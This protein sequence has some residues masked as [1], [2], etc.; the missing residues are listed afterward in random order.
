M[1]ELAL[2]PAH[3]GAIRLGYHGSV[4]VTSRIVRLA[5][6]D[7]SAVS[8]SQYDIGDPFRELRAGELDLIIVKFGLDEP[9]LVISRIL[10]HDA[11][12]VV[13]AADHPLARHDS[14]SL[15]DIAD[16]DVFDRP[17]DFPAYV[18]D[19]VVPTRT[20]SGRRIHRGHRVSSI[21]QM[22]KLVASG[23]G[24]HISLISLAEVAPPGIR[25]VPIHDMRPAPV[26]VAWL[27]GGNVP[28]HVLDFVAAAEKGAS[29]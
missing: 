15:E 17:G 25:V 11:R 10:T 21:P 29:R 19:E 5:R 18:W 1:P 4:E 27:R 26:T 2:S 6:H 22:M 16:Y 7:E 13:V 9:D 8:L 23:A 20:P 14:V 12:A 3:T 24:V 28:A